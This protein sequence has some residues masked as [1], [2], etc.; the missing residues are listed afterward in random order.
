[1][2][3]KI[4]LDFKNIYRKILTSDLSR[5][6]KKAILSSCVNQ[7]SNDHETSMVGYEGS[8]N[9]IFYLQKRKKR[10]ALNRSKES[11]EGL[12]DIPRI[13]FSL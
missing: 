12:F 13:S 9:N 4:G 6:E 5:K 8:R 10:E 11:R 7:Q 1:M 2:E 3:S